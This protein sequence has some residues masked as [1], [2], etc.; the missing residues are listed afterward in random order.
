MLRAIESQLRKREMKF[1]KPMRPYRI[2]EKEILGVD[3][4]LDG[5]LSGQCRNLSPTIHCGPFVC[6]VKPDRGRAE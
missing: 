2:L 4:A 5:W 6:L 3:V 1:S